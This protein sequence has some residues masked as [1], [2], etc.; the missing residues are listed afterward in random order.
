[1]ELD[2]ELCP[3]SELSPDVA[4][5]IRYIKGVITLLW[6]YAQSQGRMGFL[7]AEADFRIRAANG[8]VNIRAV[9]P[10]AR[11]LAAAGITVGDDLEITLLDPRFVE[12]RNHK[13]GSAGGK[14][15]AWDL[16]FDRRLIAKACR[17]VRLPGA[18]RA[19]LTETDHQRGKTAGQH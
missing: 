11:A 14:N 10:S 17:I 16:E 12:N 4:A 2:R 19:D 3:I 9:G 15:V 18:F 8:Q 7:L 6:P 13:A 5:S 1:M